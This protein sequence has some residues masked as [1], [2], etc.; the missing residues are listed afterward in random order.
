ARR[1]P[2]EQ[3]PDARSS[4]RAK[5][6]DRHP[7]L[8][9][10]GPAAKVRVAM[11]TIGVRVLVLLA[12]LASQ[13]CSYHFGDVRGEPAPPTI[14]RARTTVPQRALCTNTFLDEHGETLDWWPEIPRASNAR[15]EALLT[16]SQL[17]EGISAV[18]RLPKQRDANAAVAMTVKL[19]P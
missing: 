4:R 18:A 17:F 11:R 15:V 9:A 2:E 7:G 12:M 10:G 8:G 19:G 5:P 3:G 6:G 16:E 14:P 13:G 1:L